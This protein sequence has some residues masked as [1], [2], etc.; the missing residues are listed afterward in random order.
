ME[1]LSLEVCSYP[2]TLVVK[3]FYGLSF[4]AVEIGY[5][6]TFLLVL[7]GSVYLEVWR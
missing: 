4:D 2:V 1:V 6:G 7:R 3:K 5:T